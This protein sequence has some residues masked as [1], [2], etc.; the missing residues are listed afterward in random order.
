MELLGYDIGENHTAVKYKRK[1]NPNIDGVT[2]LEAGGDVHYISAFS[3]DNSLTIN[4]HYQNRKINL[5]F[6]KILK[7]F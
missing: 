6:K 1:L 2:V 3:S 5:N 4:P 7:F